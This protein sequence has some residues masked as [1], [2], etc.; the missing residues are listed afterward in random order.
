MNIIVQKKQRKTN[1]KKT[2]K[3]DNFGSLNFIREGEKEK[4]RR[5]GRERGRKGERK[6][7]NSSIQKTTFHICRFYFCRFKQLQIKTFKKIF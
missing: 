5:G 2:K 6:R 1:K 7:V 3:Q 4:G